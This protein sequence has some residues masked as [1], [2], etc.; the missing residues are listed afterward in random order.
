[1]LREKWA[2]VPPL[3]DWWTHEAAL[4]FVGWF[5]FQALLERCLPGEVSARV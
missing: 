1:M 3:Q 2:Q 4:V 5:V